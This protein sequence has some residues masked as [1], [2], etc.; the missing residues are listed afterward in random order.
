MT[1]IKKSA[2]FQGDMLNFCD[3][4][5]LFEFTTN[6]HLNVFSFRVA[7]PVFPYLNAVFQDCLKNQEGRYCLISCGPKKQSVLRA[8]MFR[9]H[10]NVSLR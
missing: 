7:T 9:C 5:Q 10:S 1:K 4:I 3:F 6:H 8:V 2:K